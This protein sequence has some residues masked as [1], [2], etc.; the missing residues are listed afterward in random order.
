ME[1][2]TASESF[3]SSIKSNVWFNISL[4]DHDK[5]LIT[6]YTIVL[7]QAWVLVYHHFVHYWTA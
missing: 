3:S 7:Q 2:D 1:I 4:Q 5:L 6:V